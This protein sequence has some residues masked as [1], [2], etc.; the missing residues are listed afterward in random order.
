MNNLFMNIAKHQPLTFIFVLFVTVLSLSGCLTSQK[1][2]KFVAEQYGNQLPKAGKKKHENIIV[3]SSVVASTNDISN[4]QQKTSKV[5]PLIVYWQ[6]DY[7][8]TCTLNPAIAV[9]NF[10]NTLNSLYDKGLGQKLGGGQLELKV[11]QIPSSFAL[12]DK[13]HIIWLIYAISWDRIYMEADPKDLVVSYKFT[14]GNG[15]AK[16]GQIAVK[17]TTQNKGLRFFQSWKSA[18]SEHIAE[19]NANVTA[20]T[21]NFVNKLLEEL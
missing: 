15:A 4:T 11:E 9:A 8:H 2:D 12:V 13:G 10:S 7:R 5:L 14:G 20:L 6:Y 17:N 1:M 19:Y 3:S 21:K 16:T 18:T